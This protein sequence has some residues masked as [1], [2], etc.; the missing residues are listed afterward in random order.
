MPVMICIQDGAPEDGGAMRWMLGTPGSFGI[1]QTTT[2]LVMNVIDFGFDMQA[3]IE[4][5][6]SRKQ[7]DVACDDLYGSV[8]RD[9]LC[10]PAPVP[11]AGDEPGVTSQA[12]CPCLWL[13]NSL[14]DR[15]RVIAL[16]LQ[17]GGAE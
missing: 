15:L 17:H 8:L 4:Q 9:S 2:Q 12:I 6:S 11:A 13:Q 7:S 10:L 1:P 16:A 3:A 5:V 14:A